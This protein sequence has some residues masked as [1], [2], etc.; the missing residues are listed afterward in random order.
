M[1]DDS[2]GYAG[3]TQKATQEEG[4]RMYFPCTRG[5]DYQISVNDAVPSSSISR[6]RAGEAERASSV[7]SVGISRACAGEPGVSI[8]KKE[9][10]SRARAGGTISLITG[11]DT[12]RYFPRSRGC[13]R[14]YWC[15]ESALCS[16]YFPAYARVGLSYSSSLRLLISIFRARASMSLL[17]E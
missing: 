12:Q 3:E 6:A 14:G 11:H 8:G 13:D 10:I 5:C 15:E 1:S 16:F 9:G 2:R 17:S 4:L 7:T